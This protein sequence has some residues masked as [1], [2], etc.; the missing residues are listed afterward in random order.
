MLRDCLE[1]DHLRLLGGFL[2]LHHES[3]AIVLFQVRRFMLPDGIFLSVIPGTVDSEPPF[4]SLTVSKAVRLR[5]AQGKEQNIQITN[6]GKEEC[7]M[8]PD[9]VS[10][11][12]LRHRNNGASDDC[13]DKDSRAVAGQRPKLRYSE[14]EDT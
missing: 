3:V 13:H 9:P 11:P 2:D 10:N 4:L 1:R 5:A 14:S 7:V 12:T 8:N 6:H